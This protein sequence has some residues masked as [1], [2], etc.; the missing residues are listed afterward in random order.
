MFLKHFL[1]SRKSVQSLTDLVSVLENELRFYGKT[2]MILVKGSRKNS[3]K[4]HD[5][6]IANNNK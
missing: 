3:K 4:F 6:I 2:I 1:G 5:K